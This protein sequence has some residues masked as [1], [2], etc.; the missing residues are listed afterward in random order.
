MNLAQLAQREAEDPE[1]TREILGQI[2][3]AGDHC[4]TFVQ[5]MLEFTKISC[6]SPPV[7]RALVSGCR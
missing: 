7:R 6:F 1:R 4:R 5:R 3:Q 2:H